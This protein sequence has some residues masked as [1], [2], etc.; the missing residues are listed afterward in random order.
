MADGQLCHT[1]CPDGLEAIGFVHCLWA[2][3]DSGDN[4]S[5]TVGSTECVELQSGVKRGNVVISEMVWIGLRIRLAVLA[6]SS[7]LLAAASF[8]APFREA[9]GIA[10]EIDLE[11]LISFSIVEVAAGEGDDV[12]DLLCEVLPPSSKPSSGAEEVRRRAEALAA[13]GGSAPQEAFF[14][15]LLDAGLRVAFIHH[16]APPRV[17]EREVFVTPL[18]SSSPSAAPTSRPTTWLSTAAIVIGDVV[19]ISALQK[20]GTVVALDGDYAT[21][22][23]DGGLTLAIGIEHLEL[24]VSTSSAALVGGGNTTT[25]ESGPDFSQLL[26]GSSGEEANEIEAASGVLLACALLVMAS[27]T[28]AVYSLFLFRARRLARSGRFVTAKVSPSSGKRA[29][30]YAI[31]RPDSGHGVGK[32][33]LE[34][35]PAAASMDSSLPTTDLPPTPILLRVQDVFSPGSVGEAP[36]VVAASLAVAISDAI[37]SVSATDS[38]SVASTSSSCGARE[39]QEHGRWVEGWGT[40]PMRTS[41]GPQKNPPVT[42]PANTAVS[43]LLSL[44][45]QAIETCCASTPGR[46]SV[47]EVVPHA[48]SD[49]ELE[50]S[51]FLLRGDVFDNLVEVDTVPRERPEASPGFLCS[52]RGRTA[53]PARTARSAARSSGGSDGMGK[54]SRMPGRVRSEHERV[55]VEMTSRDILAVAHAARE[56]WTTQAT[57][58]AIAPLVGLQGEESLQD[59]REARAVMRAARELWAEASD[60]PNVSGSWDQD[61]VDADL[62]MALPVPLPAFSSAP[63]RGGAPCI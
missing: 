37:D 38:A 11:S 26:A 53:R 43:N 25:S 50:V 58:D 9:L 24:F 29:A 16:L 62:F 49:H 63:P 55:R 54:G 10:L 13:E 35:S 20:A 31:V 33:Y 47:L 1:P 3:G 15:A 61:A 30:L 21:V 19:W 41:L 28:G 57:T 7:R 2:S 17:L 22:S 36:S 45:P 6:S 42:P 44:L 32:G 56:L 5:V 51:R 12:F 59:V 34:E 27:V 8:E 23:I 18:L 4:T 14:D 39:L 60:S 52:R 48:G 46:S 40:E